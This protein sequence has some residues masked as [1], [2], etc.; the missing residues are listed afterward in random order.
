MSQPIPPERDRPAPARRPP[1]IPPDEPA[2]SAAQTPVWLWTLVGAIVLLALVAGG[3]GGFIAGRQYEQAARY[4]IYWLLG[5]TFEDSLE[6]VVL[7]A[8]YAGGPASSAGLQEGDRLLAIDGSPVSSAA[9]ARRRVGRHVPGDIVRLTVARG[10]FTEQFEVPLGFVI[11]S[12]PL[13]IEPLPTLLPPPPIVGTSQDSL[14]G[15]YYRMLKP[16]D[17]FS[18]TDGALIITAWPGG[19]AARAGL[20]AGDIVLAVNGQSLSQ[21]LS[22]EQAIARF[23]PGDTVRLQVLKA[24][25]VTTTVRVTLSG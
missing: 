23:G 8:V 10:V 20:E 9:Q 2:A 11:I 5:A 4:D 17:P 6:G 15:V 16:G 18:V 3:I 12:G 24:E 21:S 7:G 25:G 1:R 14:L 22:L 19:P 13:P